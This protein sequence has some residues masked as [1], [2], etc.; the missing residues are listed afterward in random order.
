MIIEFDD[1]KVRRL[2]EDLLD[3]SNSRNRM[4]R[5]VGAELT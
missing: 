2:F 4:S 5:E 1:K 3:V